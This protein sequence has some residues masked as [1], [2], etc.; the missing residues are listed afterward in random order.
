MIRK[1]LR[2]LRPVN[3]V[4]VAIQNGAKIGKH[5]NML[6]G[7]IIDPDHAWHITIGDN[8][9]LAP[10]VHILAHDAS[11]KHE[12]GYTRLAKV[13]I[14]NKVF[15]GAG[16][17]VLPGVTIGDRVIIGAG[18]V[19][20]SDVPSNSVFGGVPARHICSYDAYIEKR[21]AEMENSPI[22]GAEYTAE[23][24]IPTHLKASMNKDMEKGVGY[25]V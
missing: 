25:V 8:V 9:T 2:K 6:R 17:I 10:N 16:S 21:R 14:G 5:F 22:F 19:V 11:T 23:N 1:I 7:V 24:N 3:P 15:I 12:L 13:S 4:N 20:S 18:S